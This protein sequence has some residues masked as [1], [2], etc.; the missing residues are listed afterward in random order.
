M[1]VVCFLFLVLYSVG[2]YWPA[3]V[4]FL[5]I[6]P[7]LTLPVMF[8]GGLT[9]DAAMSAL[10][11]QPGF[12]GLDRSGQRLRELYR[13]GM[14]SF[15]LPVPLLFTLPEESL[16]FNA[17]R[18]SPFAF[19]VYSGNI[20]LVKEVMSSLRAPFCCMLTFVSQACDY[21]IAPDLRGS[22]TPFKVGYASLAVLGSQRVPAFPPLNCLRYLETLQFIF[23]E[24][25]PVDSEDV[26]GFT[27]LHHATASPKAT[28]AMTR[29]LLGNG[30]N[31]NHRNRFGEVR[32]K[33]GT[34]PS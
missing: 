31:V 4:A 27:A 21:G 1:Y 29:C 32:I 23:D 2:I 28:E 18:I 34:S 25:A 16:K 19:A 8:D 26:M 12:I 15:F 30:A 17:M 14:I 5:H 24:G 20:L 33:L 10:L 13:A 7:A 6:N 9:V 11:S 22:E 3:I